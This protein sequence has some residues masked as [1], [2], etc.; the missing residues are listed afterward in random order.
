MKSNLV[1]VVLFLQAFE[2]CYAI[3]TQGR[4]DQIRKFRDDVFG[5]STDGELT[6]QYPTKGTGIPQ[7]QT[8]SQRTTD[9]V[10]TSK[11][12]ITS[13]QSTS[14]TQ[15]PQTYTEALLML[16]TNPTEEAE[17][18][19]PMRVT[20]NPKAEPGPQYSSIDWHV[21]VL[22]YI[23]CRGSPV[24]GQLVELK[25][26]EKPKDRVLEAKDTDKDGMVDLEGHDDEESDGVAGYI[27]IKHTCHP[28]PSCVYCTSKFKIPKEHSCKGPCPED[29]FWGI[30]VE[31][32]NYECHCYEP[33]KQDNYWRNEKK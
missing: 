10:E 15:G 13:I 26:R 9:M 12:V 24:A 31:L 6:S 1:V 21:R 4:N 27:S 30:G 7:T 23:R 25:K 5:E 8:G 33:H 14:W 3:G 17:S 29:K 20:V 2:L 32:T 19:Y 28:R 11:V 16:T 22:A 18:K